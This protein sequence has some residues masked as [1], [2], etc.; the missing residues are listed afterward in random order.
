MR[1]LLIFTL[2]FTLPATF[3]APVQNIYVQNAYAQSDKDTAR[4]LDAFG[5]AFELI[6]RDY[7]NEVDDKELIEAAIAGMLSSL[8]PH[9]S[10]LNAESLKDFKTSTSGQF[11]GLGMEVTQ[12]Q[13]FVK[14][15]TPLDDTP[16]SRAGVLAGDIITHLNGE[17][18]QGLT[19]AESV[20]M[21]RGKP[22]TK[23][24]IS[25]FREGIEPF[26]LTLKR[27][28]IKLRS[29]RSDIIGDVG[30]IRITNFSGNTTSELT[31][32][33]RD[34][35]RKAKNDDI[36]LLGFVLD[37]RNNPGGLLTQAISVT[38]AFLEQGEI[39]ST[40]GRDNANS[41]RAQAKRGDITDGMPLVVLINNGSA[42]ASEIVAGALQD[43]KRA[44]IVGTQ[45]FGKGSVQNIF[46]LRK[47]PEAA[48]K[49]TVQRYYTPSGI[50]IQG[51]GIKP[52]I[53]IPLARL[54]TVESNQRFEKDL[55]GALDSKDE[56]DDKDNKDKDKDKD[57]NDRYK[58]DYQLQRS[59]D[60]L[61]GIA[62]YQTNRQ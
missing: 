31:K 8:D 37:L 26:E 45:S 29:V 9:S 44:I 4:L 3:F 27:E 17:S 11:G 51:T 62:I 40:R 55:K 33:V 30:Y 39:V 15:I 52:D 5:E 50:S 53:E 34:M 20:E 1:Y 7:V 23:I 28:I 35:R 60:I 21:M 22:G 6:K 12:E 47:Y 56:T 18:V 16:A 57:D 59:I 58:N 36:N 42:S 41:S 46:G 32:Q 25:I 24:T 48:V 43:H 61:K 19:L 38:D 54:E 14:V 2:L 13:G 49:L 10:Y